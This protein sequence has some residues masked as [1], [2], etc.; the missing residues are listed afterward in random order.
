VRGWVY[1]CKVSREGLCK[2]AREDLARLGLEFRG[3]GGGSTLQGWMQPR[4]LPLVHF[5]QSCPPVAPILGASLPPATL[6]L[7][8][9]VRPPCML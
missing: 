6:P 2:A 9:P 5:C 7:L 3:E 8:T 4:V 1:L